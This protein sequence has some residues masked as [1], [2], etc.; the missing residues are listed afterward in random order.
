MH[1]S[2]LSLFQGVETIIAHT[3]RHQSSTTQRTRSVSPFPQE[4]QPAI[5]GGNHVGRSASGRSGS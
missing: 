4:E 2:I 3:E 5:L 1:A